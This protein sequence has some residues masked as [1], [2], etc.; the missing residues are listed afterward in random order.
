MF[1]GQNANGSKLLVRAVRCFAWAPS[2]KHRGSDSYLVSDCG[3]VAANDNHRRAGHQTVLL[4]ILAD[5]FSEW[6][7][8]I[9]RFGGSAANHVSNGVKDTRTAEVEVIEFQRMK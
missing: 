4:E 6:P 1:Q 7:C 2:E 5:P 8:C 9:C 3:L